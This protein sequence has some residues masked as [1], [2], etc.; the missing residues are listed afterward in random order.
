M[1]LDH[2]YHYYNQKNIFKIN[3]VLDGH[4]VVSDKDNNK[5]WISYTSLTNHNINNHIN[6]YIINRVFIDN[7]KKNENGYYEIVFIF[8][9]QDCNEKM[10]LFTDK[11]RFFIAGIQREFSDDE[12]ILEIGGRYNFKLLPIFK[13]RRKLYI[14]SDSTEIQKTVILAKRKENLFIA[15]SQRK[16]YAIIDDNV[17]CSLKDYDIGRTLY[18]E[19]QEKKIL[20]N[21]SYSYHNDYV[22]MPLTVTIKYILNNDLIN[23]TYKK[24]NFFL[25]INNSLNSLSINKSLSLELVPIFFAISPSHSFIMNENGDYICIDI[26]MSIR[27]ESKLVMFVHLKDN[28]HFAVQNLNFDFSQLG[29]RFDIKD[30][31]P[32]FYCDEFQGKSDTKQSDTNHITD[33]VMGELKIRL[34]EK[35]VVMDI[36][37]NN[38]TKFFKFLYFPPACYNRNNISKVHIQLNSETIEDELL[39]GYYLLRL[40]L[41]V[42]PLQIHY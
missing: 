26:S 17:T 39:L 35:M 10:I 37:R 1:K 16:R 21:F 7:I 31:C 4:V 33:S 42:L 34:K 3:E 6:G 14:N 41:I 25:K 32:C 24:Q 22:K 27:S 11:K 2:R 19:I 29:K 15:K 40:S 5:Y 28:K 23:I 12:H 8:T 9:R 38:F 13:V 30:I 18:L 36:D 20:A